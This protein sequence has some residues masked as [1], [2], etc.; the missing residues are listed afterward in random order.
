MFNEQIFIDRCNSLYINATKNKEPAF[1]QMWNTTI[2]LMARLEEVY[3]KET[4]L[5]AFDYKSV[6]TNSINTAYTQLTQFVVLKTL[7]DNHLLNNSEEIEDNILML[8]VTFSHCSNQYAKKN[9][10]LR[11]NADCI[12]SNNA[13]YNT[14]VGLSHFILK[15]D[16]D[17]N[18]EH[19][20]L[21]IKKNVNALHIYHYLPLFI[22]DF[23]Y[24]KDYVQNLADLIRTSQSDITVPIVGEQHSE[25]SNLIEEVV[26]SQE[27][28]VIRNAFSS[29]MAKEI[30][31]IVLDLG[32]RRVYV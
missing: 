20:D 28:K 21:S 15:Y 8:L 31:D 13:L 19:P 30:I 10:W 6:D 3:G 22:Y 27:T 11:K 9:N 18:S 5:Q 25:F 26:L 23:G 29:R 7:I 4:I 17:I 24:D 16:E 14:Y 12:L 32:K 1:M 2:K